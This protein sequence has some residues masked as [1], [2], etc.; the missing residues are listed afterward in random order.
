MATG[1]VWMAV[2]RWMALGWRARLVAILCVAGE[3]VN[4]VGTDYMPKTVVYRPRFD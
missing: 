3:P 4:R 1:V 2:G